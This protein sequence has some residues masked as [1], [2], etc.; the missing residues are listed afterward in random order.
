MHFNFV[1]TLCYRGEQKLIGIQNQGATCYLNS[2]IQTLFLTSEFRDCLF[3][4]GPE[5]LGS[6]NGDKGPNS[7]VQVTCSTCNNIRITVIK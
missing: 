4:L 3:N 7:N 2:L 5:E 6:I 1:S